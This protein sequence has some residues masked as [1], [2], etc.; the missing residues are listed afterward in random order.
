MIPVF[1]DESNENQTFKRNRI[2]KEILPILKQE[3][4]NF[5]KFY[6][7]F[8][9]WE[10]EQT[11]DFSFL[12]SSRPE[13]T[14]DF[15]H[16]PAQTSNSLNKPELKR[17]LD[18]YLSLLRF[19]PLY[20]SAFENF[21]NQFAKDRAQF[22]TKDYLIYREKTGV[23][24]LIRKDSSLFKPL[25][26]HTKADS[27]EIFWNQKKRKITSVTEEISVR[28]QNPGE[29]IEMPF[30][31]KELSEV[32]RENRIPYFLRDYIPILY[33]KNLPIQILLSMFDPSLSD[34]PKSIHNPK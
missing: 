12:D 8:H 28:T 5:H 18:F 23:I 32:F 7:N 34:Y 33:K 14:Q 25:E 1:E 30:G 2:R 9:E 24:Y 3:N 31:K 22:E 4:I 13:K 21:V 11:L 27:M 26:I 17:V 20:R 6:W 29:K 15:F 19:P 10:T 16:I